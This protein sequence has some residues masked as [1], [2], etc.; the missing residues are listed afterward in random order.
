MGADRQRFLSFGFV[1]FVAFYLGI[2]NTTVVDSKPDI[3]SVTL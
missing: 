3:G 1:G 2:G